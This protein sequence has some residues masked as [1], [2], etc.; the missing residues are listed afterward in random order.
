MRFLIII[1][2]ACFATA[3]A[4]TSESDDMA[5]A[6]RPAP[7]VVEQG[8]GV[9]PEND[10]LVCR[11]ESPTGTRMRERVC[12]TQAEWEAIQESGREAIGHRQT[13]GYRNY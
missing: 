11:I 1:G 6:A 9:R 13:T 7:Q 3:C 10:D 5:M 4:T 12:R 8:P 2:A